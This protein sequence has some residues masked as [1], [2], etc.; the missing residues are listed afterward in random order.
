MPTIAFQPNFAEWRAQARPLLRARVEPREILWQSLSNS[1]GSLFETPTTTAPTPADPAM[2]LPAAFAR[3]AE[4]IS[5]WR[6][7]EPW[8]LLYRIAYRLLYENPRLLEIGVD[9]DVSRAH[10]L[11]KGIRRDIHKMHAF[12]RFKRWGEQD[13][14]VAW[15]QPEHRIL[16]AAAPF[17]ARRFGDKFWSIFTA[18][19]SAHW[20]GKEIQYAGGISRENFSAKDAFDALWQDYYRSTFNPARVNLRAMQAEMPQKF[21]NNLPEA[22]VI[23]ELVRAAP[24]RLREMAAKPHYLAQPPASTSLP[25]LA[26]AASHCAS[27]PIHARATRT[28]FGKGNPKARLVIV[29][30]QPGDEEDLSGAPFIGPAGQVLRQALAECEISAESIYL[31]NAVK[32]FKWTPSDRP[33]KPRLHQTPA[34]SDVSACRPWLEHEL[35]LIRPKLVLALGRSAGLAALGRVPAIEKERSQLFTT[36]AGHQVLLSWHPAAI[37]RAGDESVAAQRLQELREDL[38][39]A[40]EI[41]GQE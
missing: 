25:E 17:F 5:L 39:L 14:Y 15:Y 6:G 16:R 11:Q 30:E 13:A 7:E 12:V 18:D 8:P 20:D 32:H 24:E 29:G 22:A 21:W 38:L 9:P 35:R 27:C 37:L 2:R 19:E 41:S 3:L 31:T 40:Q 4:T 36:A 1:Q 28:V 34:A 26:E 10:F 33:S 23:Q